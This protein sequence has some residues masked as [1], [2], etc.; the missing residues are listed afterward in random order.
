ARIKLSIKKLIRESIHN[1][2]QTDQT[3]PEKQGPH[4]PF[5][6]S[7]RHL[8]NESLAKFAITTTGVVMSLL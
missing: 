4:D 3:L 2:Q 6:T 5:I 8:F 7:H 1:Q